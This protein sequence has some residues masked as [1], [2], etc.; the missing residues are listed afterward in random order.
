MGDSCGMGDRV[1]TVSGNQHLGG[2][3]GC[4][5]SCCGKHDNEETPRS[6]RIARRLIV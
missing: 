6:R 5:Y 4:L 3:V 2:D 1:G